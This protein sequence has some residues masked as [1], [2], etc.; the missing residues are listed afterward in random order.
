MAVVIVINGSGGVGKSTF[1]ELCKK[2]NNNVVELST[3]DSVKRIATIAGWNGV[4]D[5]KGRKFLND[6]KTAMDDYDHLSWKNVDKEID[7]TSNKIYFVN[8]REP[9]DIDYFVDKY[10]AFTLLIQ[11]PRVKQITTNHADARVNDYRYDYYI[12]NSG[13]LKDFEA[14]AKDFIEDA[15]CDGLAKYN[16]WDE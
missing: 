6:I 15:S 10:W 11:N 5:E 16:F 7:I 13:T 14:R 3:V 1:I 2:F 9:E 8:A 4:K 12:T